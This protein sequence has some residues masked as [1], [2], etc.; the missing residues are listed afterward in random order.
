MQFGCTEWRHK[1]YGAQQKL[2][3]SLLVYCLLKIRRNCSKKYSIN[4][5][6]CSYSKEENLKIDDPKLQQFTHLLV[7]QK[8]KYFYENEN[9]RNTHD[10][11]DTI[12]C[13]SNIGVEYRS[14]FPI[15]IKTRPCVTILRRK[16]NVIPPQ[17][18]TL[19]REEKTDLPNNLEEYVASSENANGFVE[20]NS[21]KDTTEEIE[22]SENSLEQNQDDEYGDGEDFQ[23]DDTLETSDLTDEEHSPIGETELKKPTIETKQK[24]RRMIERHYRLKTNKATKASSNDR[25]EL[26]PTSKPSIKY[27]IR[28]IIKKE[29]IKELIEQISQIDL[30]AVCDFARESVKECLLKIIDEYTD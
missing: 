8:G 27:N 22:F 13:F 9:I 5:F 16:A 10:T 12:N 15:K 14:I 23:P 20:A 25:A 21:V 19:T 26:V 29:K 1:I 4:F 17:L 3:V 7:E 2:E 24:L 28:S 30:R 18:D 6:S 11:L